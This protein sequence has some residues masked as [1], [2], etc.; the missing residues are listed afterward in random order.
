[1]EKP[2]ETKKVTKA[3]RPKAEVKPLIR[4]LNYDVKGNKP[5]GFAM[6]HV[7]GVG[8]SFAN[9]ICKVVGIDASKKA[10]TLTSKEIEK[11]EAVI[12]DP[13]K[14]NFPVWMINRRKDLDTGK[15]MHISSSDLM[16][17]REN[18]VKT[19]RKTKSYRGLRLGQGLTV[20]GQRTKSNFRKHGKALGVKRKK[21]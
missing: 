4:I 12:K 19:M 5:L 13:L 16:F 1:M 15:D 11:I 10:G 20:R 14:H 2:Q 7:K 21:R 17:T 3:K 6:S 8:R 18:D 9:G